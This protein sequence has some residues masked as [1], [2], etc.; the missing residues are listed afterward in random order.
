M[1]LDFL[2]SKKPV[3]FLNI[4]DNNEIFFRLIKI[5]FFKDMRFIHFHK[6]TINNEKMLVISDDGYD[7]LSDYELYSQKYYMIHVINTD[8]FVNDSGL[9]SKISNIFSENDISILYITSL[10][11]NYI[12]VEEKDIEKTEKILHSL[13]NNV[14]YM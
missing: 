13:T 14:L 9:V 3:Y 1:E 8:E 7:M 4:P 6:N 2:I 11:S 5:L 12:F 10:Q